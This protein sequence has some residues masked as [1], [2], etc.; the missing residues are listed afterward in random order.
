M[1]ATANL[2]RLLHDLQ[3]TLDAMP[4]VAAMGIRIAGYDSPANGLETVTPNDSAELTYISRAL[5][6]GT[7]GN[8]SVRMADGSTAI[9]ASVPAGTLLPI[10]VRGVNSTNT[11]AGSM[12]S[13]Y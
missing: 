7:A 6:V 1:P 8:I 3:T 4:P 10:R 11:T 9:L 5:W 13:L 2:D 12:V